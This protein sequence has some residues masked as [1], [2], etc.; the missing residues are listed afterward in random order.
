MHHSFMAITFKMMEPAD[1]DLAIQ[2]LLES[3]THIAGLSS[4]EIYRAFCR[5]GVRRKQLITILAREGEKG[6]G[7]VSAIINS[8]SFWQKFCWRHPMVSIKIIAH[9][10]LKKIAHKKTA[11]SG[12]LSPETPPQG[13]IPTDYGQRLWRQSSPVIAKIIYIGVSKDYRQQGIASQ[14]YTLLF[15]ELAQRQIKRVDATMDISNP[16]SIRLHEKT[17]WTILPFTNSSLV[18]TKNLK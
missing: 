13:T 18:A 10:L 1:V 11:S 4:P 17:G 9:R 2:L 12:P 8:R 16:A 3:S 15:Q 6:A 7:F 14:L 5:E